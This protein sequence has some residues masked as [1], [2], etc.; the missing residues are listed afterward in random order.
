MVLKKYKELI[1]SPGPSNLYLAESTT[2]VFQVHFSKCKLEPMK[3]LMG[4]MLSLD[5]EQPTYASDMA[6]MVRPVTISFDFHKIVCEVDHITSCG[7][8]LIVINLKH[9]FS[10]EAQRF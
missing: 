3:N 7:V 4:G 2:C 8:W 6:V 1:S 5:S 9:N 10:S